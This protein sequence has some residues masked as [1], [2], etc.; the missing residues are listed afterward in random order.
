MKH[1][2][3]YHKKDVLAYTTI[4]RFVTRIGERIQVS[5][6][7]NE[8]HEIISGSDA[9]FVLFGIPEDIGIRANMGLGG[10]DSAWKPF[11]SSFLNLQ[12]NDFF[13]G[14]EVLLLGHFDF[15]NL[16]FLIEEKAYDVDEKIDAYR[17]AVITI[18]EE[19]E[20]LAK[21]ITS[22]KKIPIAIG[23]GHNNAYPLIKGACK[24]LHKA[25]EI[26]VPQINAINL[27]GHTDLRPIEG[28]HSGNS[29]RYAIEDG[30]LLKYYI[31][32]MN[33][34][35]LPQTVWTDIATNPSIGFATFEDIFI[36]EKKNFIQ[37]VAEAIDF[38]GD[39]FA[40]VE[41]D[42]DCVENILSSAVTPSGISTIHARQYLRHTA[43]GCKPAYLHIC[44][45][46]SELEDGR[47]SDTTGKLIS[48]LVS[49]FVKGR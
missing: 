20:Q 4:R 31:L 45:G 33:E 16:R 28:R 2:N 1:F 39:S 18:D 35:H 42:L 8:L 17:H 49:D 19:V 14:E 22:L 48:Y 21:L 29:F 41:L 3:V 37:A 10:A 44:E 5:H 12:S 26:A 38:T 15:N 36:H 13:D 34:C 25:G 9:K 40:G 30:Y 6:G 46:A 43:A 47:K 27:D 32:G 23:G 7:S 11:L 24:G